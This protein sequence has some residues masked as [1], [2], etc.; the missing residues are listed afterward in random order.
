MQPDH[1]SLQAVAKRKPATAQ[2]EKAVEAKPLTTQEKLECALKDALKDAGS[3]RTDA[4]M[5][6][7]LEFASDLS[8]TLAKHAA[9][10]E[11]L[12]KEVQK[13][14]KKKP[15]EKEFQNFLAQVDKKAETMKKLKAKPMP[16]QF[17]LLYL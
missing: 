8:E 5:L 11:A 7:S 15:T 9:G 1:A 4:T 14:L 17:L 12:Y 10:V 13:A 6:S 2:K 3:A 16:I